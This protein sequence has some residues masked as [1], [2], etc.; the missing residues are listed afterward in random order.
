MSEK[1]FR[2]LVVRETEPKT[3]NRAIEERTV[4]DLPAG[5]LLIRVAYSSLN[6]KDGL[7][8]IGNRGVSR[9]FPHTPGIDA[10]G[11]VEASDSP[12][13]A[14]GDEVLVIGYDLGMNTAGGFGEYVRVPAGWAV[15]LPAGL[16]LREAMIYGT[17]GFTAVMCVDKIRGHGVKP[18]DGEILVT[19]ATGGVGSFA[20]ALLAK[21]GYNV[22]AATGKV[23]AAGEFLRG[24]G[25]TSLISREEAIDA[26]GRPLLRGRWA[27]A[28]DTVGGEMLATAL[29][30]ADR[31]AA[32][33]ICGLVASANLNTTVL[34]FILRGVTLY[35]V[36]SVEIPLARKKRIW[37]LIAGD[38]KLDNLES[39]AREISLDDLD[40]E[41]DKILAGGQ[42]GRILVGLGE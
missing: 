26:S 42:T 7:S 22:V 15:K 8:A 13:F 36:D 35:G 38:Y 6:Y 33:A 32:I 23:E 40:P 29:A 31:D 12:D 2:A 41:I 24:L 5:D 10:A 16:S 11:V 39:L 4:A 20:V 21:F 19:G 9:N 14:A 27:G 1:T 25:A 3:F 34:P 30:S 37:G 28:V 17:A 18:E